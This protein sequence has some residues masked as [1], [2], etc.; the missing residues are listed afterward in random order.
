MLTLILNGSEYTTS[1]K[2]IKGDESG[3]Y[4]TSD[5]ILF[6]IYE[7]D[8]EFYERSFSGFKEGFD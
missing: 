5:S 4:E 2:P 3:V 8:T 6:G 7:K 1:G